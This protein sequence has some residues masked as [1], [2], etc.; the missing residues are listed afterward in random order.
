MLNVLSKQRV[1]QIAASCVVFLETPMAPSSDARGRSRRVA[2][3]AAASV[4]T[5]ASW[6]AL[7]A[8]TTLGVGHFARVRAE[9]SASGGVA[10]GDGDE[11][12]LRLI[13]QSYAPDSFGADHLPG[14]FARPLGSAQRAVTA[15]ELRRGVRVDVVQLGGEADAASPVVVAWIE[16]GAPDLEFDALRARPAAD[17]FYGMAEPASA[18]GTVPARVVLRPL[19]G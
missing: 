7:V 8:A 6:M 3:K 10:A 19:I 11:G 14:E 9:V 16:H 1:K 18:D 17:A 4:A 5:S 13:V 12:G 2:G 15:D